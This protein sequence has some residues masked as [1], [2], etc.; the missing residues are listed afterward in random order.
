M[1]ICLFCFSPVIPHQNLPSEGRWVWTHGRHTAGSR[2]TRQE[3]RWDGK[4]SFAV[5]EAGLPEVHQTVQLPAAGGANR[6]SLHT[7]PRSQ[8]QHAPRPHG[9]PNLHQV[10]DSAIA[11]DNTPSI[12]RMNATKPVWTT[13]TQTCKNHLIITKK[14]I[15]TN[16]S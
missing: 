14:E 1:L 10:Q 11:A 3:S 4:S 13:P 12:Q 9:L 6:S 15:S 8:G 5:S 7:L 2:V 16:G